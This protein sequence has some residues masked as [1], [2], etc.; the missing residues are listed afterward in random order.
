MSVD[1]MLDHK[2]EWHFGGFSTGSEGRASACNAG[3]LG[4]IPES[5]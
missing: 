5:G 4:L 1:I 3:D 2:T